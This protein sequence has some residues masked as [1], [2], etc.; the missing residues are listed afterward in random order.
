MSEKRVVKKKVLYVSN[1]FTNLDSIHYDIEKIGLMDEITLASEKLVELQEHLIRQANQ[2]KRRECFDC[3]K[4]KEL[5][6]EIINFIKEFMEDDIEIIRR[7]YCVFTLFPYFTNPH[8][9]IGWYNGYFHN[10]MF[11]RYNKKKVH[12][13]AQNMFP[14]WVKKSTSKS[15]MVDM[16]YSLIA[17]IIKRFDWNKGFIYQTALYDYSTSDDKY[18]NEYKAYQQFMLLRKIN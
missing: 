2:I 15:D 10:M 14:H 8:V 4:V 17:N 6:S 16:L 1:A 11:K 9:C 13:I 7:A 12:Y 5:P 3:D 18:N